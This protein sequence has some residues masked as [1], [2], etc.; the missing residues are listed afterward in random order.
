[1]AIHKSEIMALRAKTSCRRVFVRRFDEIIAQCHP[2]PSIE[3]VVLSLRRAPRENID[4]VANPLEH[5]RRWAQA[6]RP[7]GMGV[8]SAFRIW[9]GRPNWARILAV[10]GPPGG[11]SQR[12]AFEKGRMSCRRRMSRMRNRMQAVCMEGY[13]I[14][15][16]GIL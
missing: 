1:M 16:A 8:L 14:R 9:E 11:R 6:R 5:L 2:G 12:T 13:T 15:P 10:L 7:K 3:I 4:T